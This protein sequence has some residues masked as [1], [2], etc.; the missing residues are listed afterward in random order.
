MVKFIINYIILNNYFAES[1]L[2]HSLALTE[3]EF[4]KHPSVNL[5]NEMADDQ[6][7]EF[8]FS[9]QPVTAKYVLDLLLD[10]NGSK[11][12]GVDAIPPRLLKA[13]APALATPFD[14]LEKLLS[15]KILLG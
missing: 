2:S 12:T 5:I 1:G 3:S 6:D 9:F 4:D 11:A 13:F 7:R 8:S 15:R 14:S 10:L